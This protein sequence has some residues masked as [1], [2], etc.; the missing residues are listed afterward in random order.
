M[1]DDRLTVILQTWR[2]WQRR[3][4]TNIGY[5]PRSLPFQAG[6]QQHVSGESDYAAADDEEARITQACVDDLPGPEQSAVYNTVMSTRRPL[7]EPLEVVYLRARAMLKVA[8][9]RRGVE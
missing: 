2:D 6:G 3:P 8:L 9:N 1:T 7:G 5:P 4:N